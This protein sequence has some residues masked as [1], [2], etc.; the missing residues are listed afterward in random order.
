MA[1]MRT[2][3]AAKEW[4]MDW[5]TRYIWSKVLNR[6]KERDHERWL[7]LGW[8]VHRDRRA[9]EAAVVAI[10]SIAEW[11]TNVVHIVPNRFKPLVHEWMGQSPRA[12]TAYFLEQDDED[13]F[14]NYVPGLAEH[15]VKD[16]LTSLVT[17]LKRLAMHLLPKELGQIPKIVWDMVVGLL[18]GGVA[19]FWAVADSVLDPIE[20]WA[21]RQLA[22]LGR[23]VE[24]TT[25]GGFEAIEAALN[26]QLAELAARG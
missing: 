8:H 13:Q 18:D 16:D 14:R 2:G 9:V 17:E 1:E 4:V 3:T 22:R 10:G 25:T 21:D 11:V 6:V 23:P 26:S 15:E 5:L 19:G 24:Q 7:R 20:S 12:I